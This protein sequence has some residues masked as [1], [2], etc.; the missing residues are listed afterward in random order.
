[1]STFLELCQAVALESG[2]VPG[3]S[4]PST[5]ASQTGR[6]GRIVGWVDRAWKE[7]Q[8]AEEYWRWMEAGF[9]YALTQNVAEYSASD[10]GITRF[11]HW[12]PERPD[13]TN[14][15]SIYETSKGQANEG[16]MWAVDWGD[17]YPL[18]RV[19]GNVNTTGKPS[20]FAVDPENKLQVYPKPDATGWTIRGRYY[21]GVQTLSADDDTPEMPAK[22][23]DAI[24]W[25]ALLDLH[26]FD[27]NDRKEARAA[28]NYEKIMADLRGEQ[29]PKISHGEPMV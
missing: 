15:F 10:L 7:I 3:S 14:V 13:G 6:L 19:G 28:R 20:T 25:R 9:S 27:E 23:H 11:S 4:Q 22:F 26:G 2:T 24:M 1:M 16:F 8:N 12:L 29:I 21:K 17:F 18:Y 5:T